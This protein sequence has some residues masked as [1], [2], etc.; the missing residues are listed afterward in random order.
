M[1]FTFCRCESSD[2]QNLQQFSR[3]IFY[4]TFAAQN[5]PENMAAYLEK[6]FN[7]QQIQSELANPSSAFWLAL[8]EGRIAGYVKVNFREAQQDLKA[9]N[10]MEIERIYVDQPYQGQGLASQL[11]TKAIELAKEAAV[12]FVWLGVWE[13][14]QRAIRFYEKSGFRIFDSHEFYLGDDKQTDLMMRLDL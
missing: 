6:A 12:D 8:A 10:A 4:A 11:L 7:D 1:K 2:W 3:D 5:T 14:N 13:H 9:D